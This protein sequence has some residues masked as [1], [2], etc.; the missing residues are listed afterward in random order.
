[1]KRYHNDLP[2]AYVQ[3]ILDYNPETGIFHWKYR[4]NYYPQWNGRFAG[5]KAGGIT[6]Y[7]YIFI[8]INKKNYL[9]QRLA[10]LLMTNEWPKEDVDH[11]DT[12][13]LNNRWSNLREADSSSNKCN[14]AKQANNTSGF[15]GVSWHKRTK[16]WRA[17]ICVRKKQISLGNFDTPKKAH[18]AYCAA[19]LQLHGEF[20]HTG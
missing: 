8:R 9:A 10:W 6:Q 1:M 12:N 13:K 3:R 7:G 11:R 16:T 19:A 15:K 4:P 20:A 14:V 2:P 5:K 17:D 18:A